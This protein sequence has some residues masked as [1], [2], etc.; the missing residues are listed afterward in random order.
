ME[1]KDSP[2]TSESPM[3]TSR[4]ESQSALAATS[5][6]TVKIAESRLGF[7]LPFFSFLFSF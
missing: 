4:M 3:T 2:W 6:D 5:M 1:G 7:F